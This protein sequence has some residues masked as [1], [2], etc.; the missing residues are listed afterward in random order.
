MERERRFGRRDKPTVKQVYAL[1]AA[2]CERQG[3]EFPESRVQAS[4]L[5]ER[6]RIEASHPE[7]SLKRDEGAERAPP[8]RLR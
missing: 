2:L 1:C 3:D 5:I 8:D 4:A 6:L 7:P